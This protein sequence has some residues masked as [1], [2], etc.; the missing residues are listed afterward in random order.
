MR[1]ID[2]W[3]AAA[4]LE[5]SISIYLMEVEPLKKDIYYSIFMLVSSLKTWL[6]AALVLV[7]NPLLYSGV[8][9]EIK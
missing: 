5:I 8:N 3:L 6:I 1:W 9:V 2:F 4:T 7:P